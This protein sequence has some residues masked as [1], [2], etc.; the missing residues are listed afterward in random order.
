[1]VTKLS[2]V[3]FPVILN[4]I[5]KPGFDTKKLVDHGYSN[6][7][8]YFSGLDE[9]KPNLTY[10]NIT[11]QYIIQDSEQAGAELCQAREQLGL[12]N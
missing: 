10:A 5:V 7:Y 9:E 4:I 3:E 12:A 6:V 11:G 1:M 8:S 2:E